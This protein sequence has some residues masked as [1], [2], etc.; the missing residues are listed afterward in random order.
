MT[1][2]NRIEGPVPDIPRPA[3]IETLTIKGSPSLEIPLKQLEPMEIP[4]A[5]RPGLDH[6]SLVDQNGKK[7]LLKDHIGKV[8]IVGF[9][10]T[11]CEPSIK[12]LEEMASLQE[13]EEKFGFLAYPVN[14][15]SSQWVSVR[16]F[17]QVNRTYFEKLRVYRSGV[18]AE[19]YSGV[20]NP[21]PATPTTL[22]F[23][24][25]GRLA[26]I[27]VG[28]EPKSLVKSLKVLLSEPLPKP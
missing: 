18:G 23:D 14:I 6:F 21:L 3:R 25:Q 24:R 27:T 1:A 12:W 16:E 8:I 15:D 13:K 28:Y 11:A 7:V 4:A 5:S 10:H 9:W 20:L 26:R 22:F 2:G 17:M 19:G